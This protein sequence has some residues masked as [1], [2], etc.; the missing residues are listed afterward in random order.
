MPANKVH[1]RR[2]SKAIAAVPPRLASQTRVRSP[3]QRE[4]ASPPSTLP[5]PP[6]SHEVGVVGLE[7][8]LEAHMEVVA[9]LAWLDPMLET[10]E[11]DEALATHLSTLRLL[12][13]YAESVRDALY[14]LYCDAADPRLSPLLGPD[15]PLE[16]HVR[17]CYGWCGRVVAMLAGLVQGVRSAAGPDWVLA[18]K[19]FR[20]ASLTYVGASPR[21]RTAVQALAID[22][23]NPTEPLRH[24]LRDLETLFVATEQLQGTLVKRFS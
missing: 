11:G 24:V 16:Q 20:S 14:E 15:A 17:C 22:A 7:W 1:Q 18:K 4:G 9:E 2:D 13:E 10:G 6:F 19:G 3:V 8:W 5:P 23:A 21:L 12:A